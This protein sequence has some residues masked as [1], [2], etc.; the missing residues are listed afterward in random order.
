MS[1]DRNPDSSAGVAFHLPA[2]SD[3]LGVFYDPLAWF[4][5]GGTCLLYTS[6]CV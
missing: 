4:A 1:D 6:R 2:S 5:S 3:S